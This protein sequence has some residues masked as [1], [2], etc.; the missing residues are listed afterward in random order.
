VDIG[1]KVYQTVTGLSPGSSYVLTFWARGIYDQ[2]NSC[3]MDAKLDDTLVVNEYF[4]NSASGYMLKT[5]T[6][7]QA[8]S[9]SAVLSVSLSCYMGQST[10]RLD[11]FSLVKQ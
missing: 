8:T 11:D 5:G 1:G 10:L 2:S 6:P 9:S 4:S 7:F 3:N